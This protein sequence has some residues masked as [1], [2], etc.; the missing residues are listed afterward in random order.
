MDGN[1]HGHGHGHGYYSEKDKVFWNRY[2][3]TSLLE[4]SSFPIRSRVSE[5]HE[6]EY[7]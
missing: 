6:H 1:G 5:E 7:D 2:R 4:Y 3:C